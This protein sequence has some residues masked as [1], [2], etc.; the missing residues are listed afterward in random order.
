MM[1]DSKQMTDTPAEAADSRSS[2][3]S[4]KLGLLPLTALVIG[5]MIGGGVFSLPQNMARGASAGAITIGWLITGVGMLA[6]AFVYKNLATR[7]PTLDA[8]P[9]AYARAGFG[10]F[11][12]FNSAWGYWLSAWLGNVS[13]AVLI[14][15]ALSYFYAPFGAEGNT[16][17]AIVGASI[18]LWLLHTLVLSGVRQAA[19][20]NLI[21][22]IAK[23]GPIFLF[24]VLV[25]VAFNMQTFTLD[26]WGTE[27]LSLG[28]IT[29][30][31]KST[32]LVTLWVFIGIEGASVGSG[33]ARKRSDIGTATI[34]GFL[35]VLLVYLLVSLLSLGVMSQSELAAL[36]DAASMANVLESVVGPWGSVLVRIGLVISV[37]GAFL[38]WT[39]LAAEIPFRAA[40]E[41]ILPEFFAKEN[42]NGSP[43]GALWI[44]NIS[45]QIF[46]IVT[47][48]A[49]STYLALFYIASTAILVPYVLSGAYALKLAMT[50]E[51]YGPQEGRGRD[52]AIGALATVY[53]SW[54]VYA[55]GPAYLL[56]CAILYAVGLP[57]YLW[58]RKSHSER[59]FTP[60]EMLIALGLIGAA[61]VAGYMM[62]TGAIS[63]L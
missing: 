35:T 15:G 42:A 52:L 49:N 44:T 63:A 54:L 61:I 28:S 8:G 11:V 2:T 22:T 40:K 23:L 62:W 13:Y 36:P 10:N 33:R 26:F 55:A 32:M 57:V 19:I 39:L 27:S 4:G 58:A 20:V 25:L 45:V 48:Y 50:G 46:L 24:I 5:S 14:F 37:A 16:W 43:S 59:A 3:A 31:V 29:T 51:S 41:G 6:L 1:A 56:M 7:K 47:L 9:Y 12:G 17:Q 21:T 18:F 34:L 38:S 60:V 30:Q 53:G